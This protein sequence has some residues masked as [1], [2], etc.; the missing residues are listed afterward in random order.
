MARETIEHPDEIIEFKI[1]PPV[2]DDLTY[3]EWIFDTVAVGINVVFM[4]IWAA[5]C[6]VIWIAIGTPFIFLLWLL[7]IIFNILSYPFRKS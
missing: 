3:G 1:P 7:A 5:V 4:L 6:F 2:G